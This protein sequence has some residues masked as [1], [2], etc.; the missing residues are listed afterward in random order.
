MSSAFLTLYRSL[1]RHRL[2]AVL[3]I[4]GLALGIAV[5]LVLFLFVRFETGYDRVLPGWERVRVVKQ[6]MQFPGSPEMAIPSPMPLLG[7]IESDWPEVDGARLLEDSMP[8]Q[9]GT[10]V[11]KEKVARVD[12]A[13]FTLFPLSAIAGNPHATLETPDGAVITQRIAEIYFGKG[14]AI[15]RTLM[16]IVDGK[17]TPFQVGA[18]I[19][20]PPAAMTYRQSVYIA[21]P[22][23]D[24]GLAG[25]SGV[26]TFLRFADAQAGARMAAM[27]PAFLR[28]HPGLNFADL[29]RD[30]L[31]Q[32][33]VP[34]ADVHLANPTDRIVVGALGSVGVLALLIAI[35]NYVNLATAR[36]GLRAR[37]VAIRKVVGATRQGLV[38]QFVGE[39]MVT[40]A[41]AGLIGLALA[42]L[43]LPLVNVAGGTTLSMTY[44]GT[45]SIVPPLMLLI[46][47]VGLVAGIYPAFILARFQPAAVLASVRSP[48]GHRAGTLMRRAMVVGQFGIAIGLMIGTA[49]LVAQTRHLQASDVGF[50]REGLIALRMFGD[51]AIDDSQRRAFMAAVARLP[52]VMAV[53]QSAVAPTGGSFGIAAMHREGATGTEPMIVRAD[54]AQGFFATY[55]ARLLA[56][57]FLDAHRYRGD[58][59]LRKAPGASA[60]VLNRTA[61]RM[62]GFATPQ[63]AIGRTVRDASNAGTGNSAT[64]VGVIDDMRFKSPRDPVEPQAYYQRDQT[65]SNPVLAVRHAGDGRQLTAAM[66][67]LWRRIAPAIPFVALPVDRQLYDTYYRADAQRSHLFMIGAVLAVAIGCIGLYGLAAFDTARRIKEIGIRKT[68]GASTGDVLTLLIAQFLVPVFA[69]GVIAIPVSYLAMTR[70]LAGFDDRVALSPWLFVGAIMFAGSI[71]TATIFGQAW[72]VARSE[73]ARA[74]RY[75]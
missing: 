50:D 43:A 11:T 42:E 13:Y 53:A 51:Q 56:G 52:S 9:N 25:G 37:E 64:V 73:P 16:L 68:L 27:F 1:T 31:K 55:G 61:V 60:I 12:P 29:P 38:A 66:E 58:D 10:M 3:N 35:V 24:V 48:G 20:E 47:A 5:F 75:E 59:A 32:S 30:V 41:M 26:V 22:S 17:A 19:A 34:V 14:P 4:G 69:A 36:A 23:V 45:G 71:A 54:V 21:L 63:A 6:T 67:T 70:W 8:V 74:L 49:V 39:A 44:I 72:R 33:L 40:A 62:L 15:G 57:R 46:L 7:Q 18:V 65:L 2:Y 28:R